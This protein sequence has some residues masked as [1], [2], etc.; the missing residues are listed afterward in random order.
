EIVYAVLPL[1]TVFFVQP[2]FELDFF[3]WKI[4]GAAAIVLGGAILS[5]SLISF[6]K[7]GLILTVHQQKILKTGPYLFVRHPQYLG[8]IFIWAGWWWVWS[9]VYSFYFGMFI[10]A[11]TWLE[12]YLE[13]KLILEKQHQ[14]QY[15]KYKTEAGM[16]W[17]K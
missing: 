1:V 10:V 13:E 11:L 5:W 9:A 16:F 17:I 4:A 7:K 12:A 2:R 14:A 3:W 6:G 8:L 15:H